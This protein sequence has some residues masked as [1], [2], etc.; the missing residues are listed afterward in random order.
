MNF[1]CLYRYFLCV[2]KRNKHFVYWQR[3]S[4]ANKCVCTTYSFYVWQTENRRRTHV[5]NQSYVWFQVLHGTREAYLSLYC[6]STSW[7]TITYVIIFLIPHCLKSVKWLRYLKHLN[8]RNTSFKFKID[9][10][11]RLILFKSHMG[12]GLN[13]LYIWVCL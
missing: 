2:Y 4:H 6:I 5:K 13:Q 1:S 8:N 10:N 3:V 9:D 12:H 11:S 7:K